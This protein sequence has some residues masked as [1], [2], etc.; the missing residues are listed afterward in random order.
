MPCKLPFHLCTT[1]NRSEVV[2]LPGSLKKINCIA[3]NA[4]NKIYNCKKPLEELL[5]D[6]DNGPFSLILNESTDVTT[7]KCMCVCNKFYSKN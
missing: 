2:H 7:E 4:L 3:Q 1:L 5:S 6:V